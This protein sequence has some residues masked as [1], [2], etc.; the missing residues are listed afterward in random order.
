MDSAAE[1]PSRAEARTSVRKT[2][3]A[4]AAPLL[5]AALSALITVATLQLW[6]A[7][8]H[9]PL[10]PGHDTTS[11]LAGVRNIQLT[12]WF[13]DSPL[14]NF[15]FGQDLRGVPAAA[16]DTLHMLLL[17]LLLTCCDAAT[18][19]N[20]YY[21]LGFPLIAF[22][23]HLA[24][25]QLHVGDGTAAFIS[26]LFS[27][28]PYH[29]AQSEQHL[30]LSAYFM[31]PWACVAALRVYENGSLLL[32]QSRWR[33][34]VGWCLAF[35]IIASTGI[36]Y[37]AF[38][39]ALL[40]AAGLLHVRTSSWRG[41]RF[42][43]AALLLMLGAIA[44]G[45]L[46]NLL[47]ESTGAG[48]VLYG[49]SYAGTEFFGLKIDHLVLP[50]PSHRVAAMG[51]FAR[52]TLEGPIPGE[53]GDYLGLLAA[54]GA[55]AAV[56]SLLRRGRSGG[57]TR[58]HACGALILVAVLLGTVAGLSGVLAAAGVT[59][60]R[61]W[62]RISIFIMFF[63]LLALTTLWPR[64]GQRVV[65]ALPARRASAYLAGV[66]AAAFILA[67]LDQTAPSFVPRYAAAKAE[68][69]EDREYFRN[70]ESVVGSTGAVFQLPYVEYPE[71]IPPGP[72]E[73]YDNLRGYLHTR[74][75]WSSGGVRGETTQW[76]PE[77]LRAGLEVAL[78]RIQAVG[79]TAVTIDRLAYPDSGRS[80][81]EL[82][83]RAAP[84]GVL[85]DKRQ[86]WV[87]YLLD[88]HAPGSTASTRQAARRHILDPV[89]VQPGPDFESAPPTRDTLIATTASRSTA[90]LLNLRRDSRAV[91]L[92]GLA[93]LD[94]P[95][96]L[97][98]R[99][100][101][102]IITA[103]RLSRTAVQLDVPILLPPNET[104]LSFEFKTDV[105]RPEPV[106]LTLKNL[107]VVDDALAATLG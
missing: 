47:H 89:Q 28:A 9:V 90:R 83:R 2:A 36:Y 6:R 46:P 76:Q 85:E 84:A 45:A 65:S 14:L 96:S 74:L 33:G 87:T 35:L 41:L 29:F 69:Y 57:G 70:V 15:P 23:C 75:R 19:L 97:V 40:V 37:A 18:A 99:G 60:I 86:R 39:M 72:V 38:T 58:L 105:P 22:S 31:V 24:L 91:R 79:F 64:V 32:A 44:V 62:S 61:T 92:R 50:M 16:A 63:G 55:G 54:V 20:V 102:G 49:R 66:V 107:H 80:V 5:S 59:Y 34:R 56:V 27:L 25:R 103:R 71:G 13:Q 77:A 51:Q 98:I 7:D 4:T 82:L 3:G 106:R 93:T 42:P 52:R 12:G 53:G 1:A 43:F 81:E 95:G 100:A 17:K 94:Q 30:F 104:T 101:D 11:L 8:L 68:W 88:P 73:S 48:A 26:T 21:L 67:V 10:Y 78:R